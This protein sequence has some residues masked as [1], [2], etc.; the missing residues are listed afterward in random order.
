MDE[1]K[2]DNE[3]QDQ[4]WGW[5]LNSRKAHYFRNDKRALC[6]RWAY[7][8]PL[9]PDRGYAAVNCCAQCK[10]RRDAE[11]RRAGERGER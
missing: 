5:P 2:T 4:G 3:K 8:G 9:L 7:T 6:G 1:T 11:L 10:R